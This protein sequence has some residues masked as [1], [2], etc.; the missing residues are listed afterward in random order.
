M[1]ADLM[2]DAPFGQFMRLITGNRVF[3]YPEEREGYVVPEKY[4]LKHDNARRLDDSSDSHSTL[5]REERTTAGRDSVDA[6]TLV[7]SD[8][9]V[10]RKYETV[11]EKQ[12]RLEPRRSRDDSSDNSQQQ[13]ND[14]EASPEEQE[15]QEKRHKEWKE[16]HPGT[17]DPK[18]ALDEDLME[19]YQY[20]VDF[21]EGDQYNP[22]EWS[23]RKQWF[24][25]AQISLMTLVVY[26]GSAIYT[27]AEQGISAKYGVSQTVGILGL[28]LFIL[29]YGTG[30]MF[31][32]P[33]QE[34]PH[35]GRNIIYWIGLFLFLIFQIPIVLP[36]N[37]TCLLIFRFLTGF[38]G[39]PVLASGG[40]SMADIF[41]LNKL[42]Y[43]MGVWATGAVLGPVMGPV[44]AGFPA[45]L[46]G[47]RWPIY[48]LIWM[49]GFGFI[50]FTFFLPET[51]A[52]YILVRRAQR[53][54][55]LTGND[56]IKTRWE[57]ENP[58]GQSVV[59][60]GANQIKMAFILCAEPTVLYSNLYIGLLYS[61][62]YLWFEA[63]PIVFA[64]YH[65]MNLGISQL[66]FTAFLVTGSMTLAAYMLYHKYYLI[67]KQ[68]AANFQ[69]PPELLLKLALFAVPFI[70]TSLFIFGWTGN[71]PSTH[72][73][74]PTIG[75]ALYFPGIFCAFQCI[76]LYL[77]AS[78]PTVAA[79][80]LAGN[81]L[82]RSCMAAGFPLFGS[83][84]FKNLGV[85]PASSLLA[86]LNIL[87]MIPL[88]LLYFYGDRLRKRSKYGLS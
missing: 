84:F 34:T 86:G 41:P 59:K 79:S 63:F 75:A 5:A 83:F 72:W 71:S 24:C 82:F 8:R 35:F 69:N 43:A 27:P 67:P 36:S 74:G 51:F 62:F 57:L 65:G 21:E 4:L 29:G 60:M 22:K 25:A 50:V 13:Q 68:E 58:E 1:V 80:I 17:A 2:R 15:Q 9:S 77:Q 81:D 61:T 54:R 56:K 52:P 88:Y 12:D 23:Q 73:I 42:P 85:G 37:L 30:P 28:T 31:F 40:A 20:L 46:A 33:L 39:S 49:A 47:W 70:P 76:L 48:E 45:M 7:D 6:R 26:I 78:Y 66:P 3:K 18:K 87:F 32:S 44:V 53:L 16:K 11:Q 19:K 14:E 64:E 38:V 10:R 55:K